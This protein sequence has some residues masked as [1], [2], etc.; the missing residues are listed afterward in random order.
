MQMMECPVMKHSLN[1]GVY[2]VRPN[3][4]LPLYDLTLMVTASQ[5]GFKR[6]H[7]SVYLFTRSNPTTIL[8]ARLYQ[9]SVTLH[10]VQ[11]PLLEGEE[12]IRGAGIGGTHF[13]RS[14]L[15]VRPL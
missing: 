13:F 1:R 11:T 5:S 3:V 15:F 4:A 12:D 7:Y 8:K 2:A 10:F 6:F 14:F 9:I